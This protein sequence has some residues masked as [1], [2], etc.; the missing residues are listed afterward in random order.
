MFRSI[1]P[2]D[3]VLDT[4]EAMAP[5]AWEQRGAFV[6]APTWVLQPETTQQVQDNVRQAGAE[7]IGLVPQGG[8]SGLVG[9]TVATRGQAL[10]NF[11]RMNRI[12]ALRPEAAAMTAEAGCILLDIKNKAAEVGLCFP[13]GLSVAS[14][15]RLGGNIASNAGGMNVLRYGM[16]R[17]SVLGLE[18]V[19]ADGSVYSDLEPSR[20]K[21]E[22]VDLKHLFIGSEGTLGLITAATLALVPMPVQRADILLANDDAATLVAAVGVAKALSG[23]SLSA[24]EVMTAP[25]LDLLRQWRPDA[26]AGLVLPETAFT[27]L[28]TLE[29][30]M[31]EDINFLA[32]TL[33]G[34]V[35]GRV[36]SRAEAEGF[37]H[38]RRELPAVQKEA[39]DSVKHDIAVPLDRL[40]DLFAQA[41][42]LVR[43][44]EPTARCI[45]FGHFGDGNIH[46][47][48]QVHDAK[49]VR[50]AINAAIFALVR[51]L[52]GAVSA[53][54]GIGLVRQRDYAAHTDPVTK[55]LQRQI[56]QL[57][58]PKNIFNPGKG[59][60]AI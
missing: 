17:Q 42:P 51:H 54:H 44:I 11:N 16:T 28:L 49:K 50:P 30:S 56:K 37:W 35:Q 5:F 52:G 60:G 22:G 6:N 4:A 27:A 34:R 32:Q 47:N 59:A 23:E 3:A 48:L 24:F 15:C 43:A 46:Y 19:L 26:C 7:G 10:V 25:C 29:T 41:E 36:L 45:S 39:G 58:D 40:P 55:A 38:L 20:K 12:R 2:P 18:V 21:N 1:L 53:E 14:W 57:F 33:A 8:N 13:L 9:G 31:P